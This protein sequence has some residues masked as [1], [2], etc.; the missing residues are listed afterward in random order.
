MASDAYKKIADT[1]PGLPGVYR[2]YDAQN[3]ILY[4]GKAKHLKKRIS[5]Y[6]TSGLKTTKTIE[7]VKR[8]ERIEY[9]VVDSENDA[10]LLENN[11]IKEHQPPYNISLKDDKS[12]PYVVIKNEPFPRVFFTRK[13]RPDGAQYFG[14][15]VSIRQAQTILEFVKKQFPFRSCH[16]NLSEDNIRRKKFRVC[17]EYHLGNCKGPCQGFQSK[18]AYEEGVNKLTSLLKGHIQ[19]LLTEWKNQVNEYAS[20]LQ[21]EDAA[22]IQEKIF[23]LEGYRSK[24]SVAN[25]RS[26]TLDVFAIEKSKER[27]YVHYLATEEGNIIRTQTIILNEVLESEEEEVLLFAVGQLRNEHQSISKE[28]I[29]PYQIEYPES[30]IQITIPK[31]GEKLKLLELA[32]KNLKHYKWTYEQRLR[33][34]LSGISD[35]D[36][37]R[38]DLLISLQEELQLQAIPLHIECFDNSNIQ[39]AHPVAGMVCFKDGIPSKQDYRKFHIKSVEGIDDFASMKEVVGRRYKRLMEENAP[40]P[41][42]VII[43]GGKGQLNAAA[44]AIAELELSGSLTL[45]GLAKNKEEI[46]FVGDKTS[47]MLDWSHPA[48][49]LIRRIRD[50]VH[51]FGLS[52]HRDTRSKKALSNELENIPGIGKSTADK[53]LSKF[54]SVA[55]I[56]TQ[57]I[58]ALSQQVGKSKAILIYD[59]F[60]MK[61][62][63]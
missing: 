51:R 23:A 33:K 10:F 2:Y 45:V 63:G 60:K 1:I 56:K 21:F 24:S 7:L 29:L 52:F 26:G 54:R 30:G 61:E 28:I 39:G 41:Q 32:I 37:D 55:K 48:L 8:I 44:E 43:D 9:T 38:K 57:S 34:E 59:F 53:L 50:E 6:F 42:L 5:S 4:V 36:K 49:Q 3:Q 27:Y 35:K 31:A 47:V 58:D 14:P 62:P 11:L 40:L 46:F 16:L 18:E 25:M 15:Y 12:Y 13:K 20:N 22:K 17:L 19:P